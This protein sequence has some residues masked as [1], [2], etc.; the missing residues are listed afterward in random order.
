L[1]LPICHHP[2]LHDHITIVLVLN[3]NNEAILQ[4]FLAYSH[5]DV[6]SCTYENS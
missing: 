4:A 6:T 5:M 2:A 1:N 3:S